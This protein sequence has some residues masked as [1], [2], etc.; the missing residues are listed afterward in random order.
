MTSCPTLLFLVQKESPFTFRWAAR[1]A[2][3]A[4]A[5]T[6]ATA[7]AAAAATTTA[8]ASRPGDRGDPARDLRTGI[9]QEGASDWQR[10]SSAAR[11]VARNTN[12]RAGRQKYNCEYN[13]LGDYA[14]LCT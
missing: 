5:T 11:E 6:S 2:A 13:E 3:T 14:L 8:T 1:A 9:L 10:I 12:G 7:T 4:L